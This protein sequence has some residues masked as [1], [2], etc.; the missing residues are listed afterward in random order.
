MGW[1]WWNLHSWGTSSMDL[2]WIK[3]IPITKV[4]PEWNQI[5]SGGLIDLCCSDES[6]LALQRLNLLLDFDI[7]KMLN[8]SQLHL[9]WLLPSFFCL[10]ISQVYSINLGSIWVRKAMTNIKRKKI[11]M[12]NGFPS[13]VWKSGLLQLGSLFLQINTIFLNNRG[14]WPA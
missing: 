8:M 14:V 6:I 3:K 2:S 4:A 5:L 11:G 9:A 10:L 7:L 1:E 12:W 13:E